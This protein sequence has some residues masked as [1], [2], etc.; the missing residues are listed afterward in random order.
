MGDDFIAH[1]SVRAGPWVPCCTHHW[2]GCLGSSLCCGGS[3]HWCS[4]YFEEL[5]VY[6]LQIWNEW[7]QFWILLQTWMSGKVLVQNF[8]KNTE[9]NCPDWAPGLPSPPFNPAVQPVLHPVFLFVSQSDG[10]CKLIP[11]GQWS[12]ALLKSRGT[13][14][15]IFPLSPE[16]VVLPWEDLW[17]RS[18]FLWIHT[19]CTILYVPFSGAQVHLHKFSLVLKLN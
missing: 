19:D 14:P 15:I 13:T 6:T 10:L 9:Q 4:F 3:D 16:Q 18:F 12:K 7:L 11:L 8:N 5:G 1:L 2:W 17:D